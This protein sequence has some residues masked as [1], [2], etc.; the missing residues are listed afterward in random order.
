[1]LA[2]FLS[3]S[4]CNEM[5]EESE[6]ENHVTKQ[7]C[8]YDAKEK[9]QMSRLVRLIGR[10][11]ELKNILNIS[12]T[13]LMSRHDPRKPFSFQMQWDLPSRMVL[14]FQMKPE[15]IGNYLSH[16]EITVDNNG[17]IWSGQKLGDFCD[18]RVCG[19][20]LLM[21]SGEKDR[22]ND[23]YFMSSF[24]GMCQKGKNISYNYHEFV[25]C[26][27]DIF[28]MA[29]AWQLPETGRNCRYIQ[30]GVDYFTGLLV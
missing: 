26:M 15:G 22:S 2:D 20:N 16:W 5:I 18:R 25:N 6:E 30:L 28:T 14:I 12:K 21:I 3:G 23:S 27:F 29:F 19:E 11:S 13:F 10:I 4:V 1:M 24:S 8:C 7:Y 9:L 17:V